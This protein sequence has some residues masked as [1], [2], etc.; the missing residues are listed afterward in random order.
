MN[1]E[2][3]SL[4]SRRRFPW[5]FGLSSPK[6]TNNIAQGKAASAASKRFAPQKGATYA[7]NVRRSLF[8]HLC[9]AKC[10][11]NAWDG[12]KN[13]CNVNCI[14]SFP[15]PIGHGTSV[16]QSGTGRDKCGMR[17]GLK[18]LINRDERDEGDERDVFF[19]VLCGF[20]GEKIFP[21]K[22]RKKGRSISFSRS[23]ACLAGRIFFVSFRD[24][25][26][27]NSSA[28]KLSPYLRAGYGHKRY[29]PLRF[30]CFAG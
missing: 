7:R 19:R 9:G 5:E 26:W 18:G 14:N 11:G 21:A 6:V 30:W 4:V 23:F 17:N 15:V 29:C 12:A 8:V 1:F 27:A 20:W 22:T 13:D 2:Q 25:S 10:F 28:A 24:L 3:W 16:G